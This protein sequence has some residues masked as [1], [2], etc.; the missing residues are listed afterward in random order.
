MSWN[1]YEIAADR[2]P[3]A[4]GVKIILLLAALSIF[5]G[6]VNYSLGLFQEV[7]QVSR[8]ELGPKALLKK[9]EWFKNASAQLDKK[10]ADIQ[11]YQSRMTSMMADYEGTRRKDWDRTDK[12]S[13]NLWQTE[14][15]GVI[16]SYN[17]LAA[18]YNAQMSK[19]NWRFTNVGSLPAGATQVFPREFRN[20]KAQ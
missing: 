19:V 3:M 9:Y 13:F 15:V 17:G 4:I 20:Y 18:E 16:A 1:S 6:V 14:V 12:E 10:Q 8:E 11:I 2:G 5:A 7:A